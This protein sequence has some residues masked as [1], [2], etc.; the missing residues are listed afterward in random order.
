MKILGIAS[1]AQERI[2]LDQH[3]RFP[4]KVAIYNELTALRVVQGSLTIDRLLQ[5][6]RYVLSKKKILRT[7]LFFNDDDGTLKQYL[8]NKHRTFTLAAEQIFE[9]ENELQDI[10]YQ[11]IIDPDLFDLSNGRVLHCQILR[12]QTL[13]NKNYD[14]QFITD[15]DVIIIAFHHVACDRSGS[16]IFLNDLCNAYNSN[17]TWFENEESLQ[18]I[19]YSVHERLID[20]T[21]SREFW[22]LQLRGYNLEHRLPLPI[23]RHRSSTDQRSGFASV[24]EISFD[25]VISTA[26]LNYASSHQVT[27]YQLALSTFYTFLFKLTHGQ[28][29]LCISCINANRYRTQLENMIGMFVS[30]LPYRIQ[31]DPYWSFDELVK[32]VREKCLSILEHS[33]KQRLT[34]LMYF[35]T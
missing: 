3:V 27:L 33:L 7:S 13:F 2:L 11:K 25:G 12:Q 26:F 14:S 30:T 6:L 5:A 24:A 22:Y 19:D 8:T 15:S 16:Q 10:I 23:D 29:N 9:N 35:P 31:L 4:G 32:N 1:F 20:M 21:T 28:H 34:L 18:Y 17:E